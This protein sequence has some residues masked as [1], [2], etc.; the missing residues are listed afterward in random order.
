MLSVITCEQENG[1]TAFAWIVA[2]V[3]ANKALM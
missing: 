1:G 3:F 2:S